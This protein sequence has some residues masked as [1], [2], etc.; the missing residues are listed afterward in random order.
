MATEGG[1][2]MKV[3]EIQERQEFI[4]ADVEDGLCT[5]HC[6]AALS[7]AEVCRCRCRGQNHGGLWVLQWAAAKPARQKAEAPE[8]RLLKGGAA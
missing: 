4:L 7:S 6:A 2:A 8:L 5:V 3:K 1:Q